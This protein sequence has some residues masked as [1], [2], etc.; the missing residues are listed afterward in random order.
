MPSLGRRSACLSVLCQI[1]ARGLTVAARTDAYEHF[2]H[3]RSGRWLYNEQAQ[4]SKRY[5]KFN[6]PALQRVAAETVGSGCS[7]MDKLGEGFYN[8][9]F[10]L[11]M[12]NGQ[13]LV[14]KLPHFDSGPPNIT[15]ASEAATMEFVS[16]CFVYLV[17]LFPDSY[18]QFSQSFEPF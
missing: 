10:S 7:A 12:D 13:E 15:I 1:R 14:A 17:H 5:V 2:F 18:G 4:L 11:K 6:A 9:A 8:K 16:F 3:Y